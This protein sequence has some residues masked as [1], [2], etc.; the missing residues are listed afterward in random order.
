MNHKIICCSYYAFYDE[1]KN[2]IAS[3]STLGDKTN[4]FRTPV[5]T[6]YARFTILDE[7]D[8]NKAYISIKNDTPSPYG[9]KLKDGIL[10]D[11][12]STNEYCD[13][14]GEEINTFS[15]ILCI[16]DSLTEGVFNYMENDTEKYQTIPKY[17]YPT[18]LGKM[19]GSE[20]VNKGH[21]GMD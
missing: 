11:S 12:A 14:N 19:I 7:V 5:G 10:I 15:K 4:P 3:Y 13:Y 1:S 16:G 21:S 18:Q 2:L 9:Y 17:S 8:E 6:K 20:I